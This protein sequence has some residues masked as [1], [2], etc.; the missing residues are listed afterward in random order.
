MH[1]GPGAERRVGALVE[2][3]RLIAALVGNLVGVGTTHIDAAV[4]VV[5][6][7]ELGPDLKVPVGVLRDQEARFLADS[8]VGLDDAIYHRPI[9]AADLV[10]VFQA[11]RTVNKRDP[12]GVT[13]ARHLL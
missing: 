9:G 1:D 12:P 6:D 7:P 3:I 5:A 13:L 11:P 8:L 4:G 10:P 2:D